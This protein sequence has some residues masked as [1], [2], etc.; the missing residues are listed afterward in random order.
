MH[1]LPPRATATMAG[2]RTVQGERQ[3]HTSALHLPQHASNGTCQA[4]HSQLFF[5]I[6]T[7]VKGTFPFVLTPKDLDIIAEADNPAKNKQATVN[8]L[9]HHYQRGPSFGLSFIWKESLRNVPTVRG[10]SAW[11]G[12]LTVQE[13]SPYKI[14][15]LAPT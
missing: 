11:C 2:N 9:S 10:S 5:L 12:P 14:G 1:F 4:S 7:R 15:V 6:Q 3:T 13:L 8:V